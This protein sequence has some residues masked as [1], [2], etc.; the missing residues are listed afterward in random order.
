MAAMRQGNERLNEM[1]LQQS[2]TK[3]SLSKVFRTRE[4]ATSVVKMYVVQT[5]K[6]R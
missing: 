5:E 4:G 6:P 3:H 2:G 1:P